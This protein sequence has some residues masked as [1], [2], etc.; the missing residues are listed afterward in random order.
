MPYSILQI[1]L[2]VDEAVRVCL[3]LRQETAPPANIKM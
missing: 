2:L 3:T 1:L